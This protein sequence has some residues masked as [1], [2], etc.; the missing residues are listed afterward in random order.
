M[1]EQCI[2]YSR[3]QKALEELTELDSVVEEKKKELKKQEEINRFKERIDGIQTT[4]EQSIEDI[5]QWC[6][7]K[8]SNEKLHDIIEKYFALIAFLFTTMVDSV[9]TL[10]VGHVDDI[11]DMIVVVLLFVLMYV[12]IFFVTALYLHSFLDYLEY[13]SPR[14]ID[15]IKTKTLDVHYSIS[16]NT[17]DCP[18]E[19]K[20]DLLNRINNEFVYL[21][22]GYG[23]HYLYYYEGDGSV[24][25][26]PLRNYSKEYEYFKDQ[27]TEYKLYKISDIVT[28]RSV[29]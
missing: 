27:L 7:N 23:T 9:L 6:G 10:L 15:K 1:A 11:V 12:A 20:K 3:Q 18:I 24:V 26:H 25:E 19:V 29:K 16:E 14:L 4:R 2:S 13:K 8:N 28:D 21:S 17:I 22:V 5:K